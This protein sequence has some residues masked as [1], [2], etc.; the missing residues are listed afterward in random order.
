MKDWKLEHRKVIDSFL[1]YLNEASEAFVL[2]GGTAL[3]LCYGLDRFSED[4]DMDGQDTDIESIV[5][6]FCENK[7]FTYRVGKDTATVKRYFLN[8]GNIG[9]PLKV[10]VSFRKK[11]ISA[12]ETRKINGILVYDIDT[13]CRMKTNAYSSRDKIRDLYDV[14]FICNHY[15]DDLSSQTI[16]QMQ[17]ALSYKGIEQFDYILR[18]Q[19]DELIDENKLAADFLL[20]FDKLELLYDERE[21]DIVTSIEQSENQNDNTVYPEVDCDE[22]EL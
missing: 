13:L 7:G 16:S 4:I 1:K 19:Q 9:K 17:E 3:L 21:K 12:D 20:M 6:S 10:E 11:H 5:S 22:L 18:E 15:Y 8:Y 14:T 2:K